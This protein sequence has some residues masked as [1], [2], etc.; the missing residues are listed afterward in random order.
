MS[1]P[2]RI[3]TLHTREL[4]R[5]TSLGAEQPAILDQASHVSPFIEMISIPLDADLLYRFPAL[6][7]RRS[8]H[9][10]DSAGVGFAPLADKLLTRPRV[11]EPHPTNPPSIGN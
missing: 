10:L 4:H 1:N 3:Y 7:R 8:G 2:S 9:P 5:A 11:A 6:L